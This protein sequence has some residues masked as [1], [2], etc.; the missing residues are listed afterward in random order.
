MFGT[1]NGLVKPM[2]AEIHLV[3]RTHGPANLMDLMVLDQQLTMFFGG[4]P[5][6]NM[7]ISIQASVHQ[8]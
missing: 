7:C 4:C 8:R 1:G 3:T 5:P 2:S 6:K